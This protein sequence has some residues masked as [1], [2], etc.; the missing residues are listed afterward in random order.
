MLAKF[1]GRLDKAELTD[2]IQLLNMVGSC[3]PDGCAKQELSPKVAKGFSIGSTADRKSLRRFSLRVVWL[4][5][6]WH[7]IFCGHRPRLSIEAAIIARI[8][9]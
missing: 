4:A 9:A 8:A 3:L 1:A 5:D 2:V 7:G 6:A